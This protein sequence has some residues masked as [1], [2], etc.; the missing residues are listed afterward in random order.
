MLISNVFFGSG[1][2]VDA[3]LVRVMLRKFYGEWLTQKPTAYLPSD[4]NAHSQ[5]Y[6]DKSIIPWF[7]IPWVPLCKE[8]Y[9]YSPSDGYTE[10]W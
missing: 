10:S 1:R 9:L 4:K 2:E 7:T 6:Q 5:T 3:I 8:N